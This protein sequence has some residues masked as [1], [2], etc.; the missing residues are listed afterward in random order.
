M[1]HLSKKESARRD[2]SDQVKWIKEHG[3]TLLGYVNRYG[4]KD[5]PRHYGD[6]GEAI[7]AADLGELSSRMERAHRHGVL[8]SEA[9][10]LLEAADL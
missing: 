6:G 7:Y 10:D 3:A 8:S 5:D 4:S 2:L 1:K 9:V